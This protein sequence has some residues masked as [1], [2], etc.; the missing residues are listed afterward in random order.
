VR[1]DGLDRPSG[2][3]VDRPSVRGENREMHPALRAVTERFPNVGQRV[4][5]LFEQDESFH[6]LCEEYQTCTHA[7]ARLDQAGRA[8]KSSGPEGVGKE[9]AALLLRLEGELI[10]Y[11]EEH[12]GD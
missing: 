5:E 12:P 3:G 1:Q 4:A 10:R 7:L 6:E 9:Y 11:L 8:G 2:V